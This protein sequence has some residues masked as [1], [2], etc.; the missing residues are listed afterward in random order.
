MLYFSRDGN[1]L[2]YLFGMTRTQAAMYT[3]PVLGGNARML[4]LLHGKYHVSLSPDE[5]R[6]A[7]TTSESIDDITDSGLFVVNLDGSG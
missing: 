1:S 4:G 3:M 7:L 6:L 5:K 2:F